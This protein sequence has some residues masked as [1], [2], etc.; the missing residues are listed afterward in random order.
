MRSCRQLQSR[1]HNARRPPAS[2][3]SSCSKPRRRTAMFETFFGFKKVP[4][5]DEPDA[6]QLFEHAGWK[7]VQARLKFLRDD[8]R[9]GYL[10]GEVGSGKSTAARTWLGG[11]NPNLFKVIYLHWSSGSSLDLLRQIARGLDLEPSHFR[12]DLTGQISEA[13]VRLHKTRKQHPVLV[14]DEAQL[15]PHPALE[16]LPLLLNFEMD[17]CRYLTLLLAGQPLLRRALSLQMHEALRQ[18]I[19]VHYHMEGNALAQG[20]MHL[21]DRKSTRLNSSHLVISYAVFCLKKK[22][23]RTTSHYWP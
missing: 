4:F 8:R 16:I 22:K 12:G 3:M 18:R 23:M 5:S 7:Q 1:S 6:K 15:L 11:L 21:K 19:A 14:L 9:A 10:T 20:F 2:T 17:S 13:I